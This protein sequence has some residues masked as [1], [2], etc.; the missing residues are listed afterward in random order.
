MTTD[1]GTTLSPRT[2]GDGIVVSAR[3]LGKTFAGKNATITALASLD[4]DVP[5]GA[6]TAFVGPDGAGKTTFLRMICGLLA[7]SNGTLSVLGRDAASQAADIQSR[8]SY[9]PQKFGLYEDLSVMEN[10]NL[11]ADLHGVSSEARKTRFR[12]LLDMT[13]LARFTA[14]PA[15]KL[16]GGMKQKLA[17]ACT[18]V[19]SPE[20]LLL[21]EPSVGV[22]PLSRRELWAIIAGMMKEEQLS[23]IVSTAYMDEAERCDHV[24]VL[25]EGRLLAQGTPEELRRLTAGLCFASDVP[26]GVKARRLQAWLLDQPSLVMDAVPEGSRVRF[27]LAPECGKNGI[28]EAL[29]APS[30]GAL[31]VR[32]EDCRPVAPRLEDSFMFLLRHRDNPAPGASSD[33]AVGLPEAESGASGTDSG[34][35]ESSAGAGRPGVGATS[36]S[37]GA[38]ASPI[39]DASPNNPANDDEPVIEVRDL[40]RKFGNFTAVA[41]TSFSVRRGEVFGLLGPNGAG[42]T[43]TFRMLCGL[44]PATSGYLRVAGENLRKAAAHARTRVGYVS[45]KFSL[46]GNLSVLENLRF[47]GGVYGLGPFA[48]RRRI[49]EV[50][51]EFDLAGH[52]HDLSGAM[53]GGFKQRLS[54][55]VGML[56]KPEILFLD[57]P[58]SGIDPLA[59]RVFWRRITTLSD[60]GTTIIITT[61]FMEEAEYCD[62]MLIQD[63][64]RVLA[65]GTPDE[66]RA[67]GGN[68][69]TM[70]EAFIH[71]V[72]RSRAERAAK[73]GA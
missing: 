21:D 42:K 35:P 33:A 31:R 14:R 26:H 2:P 58:T 71:I 9:M 57:E 18:L 37:S 32:P 54:M 45:Q 66:V 55:A 61:H 23:V 3:A 73:E 11:Y 67:Q 63:A 12:R 60:E 10:L 70:E 62:R 50:L 8:I 28:P 38:T 65:L 29:L 49:R 1:D 68:A 6:M 16:S 46:Y 69:P 34:T 13:D 41:S 64:G 7:P 5:A 4:L 43:T 19:R 40:V 51:E 27:V 36:L 48:L 72:E 24:V 30:E 47:F 56:H 53:P 22:D 15:G 25:H 44:L 52:E 17:L 39:N 20:L 59:R